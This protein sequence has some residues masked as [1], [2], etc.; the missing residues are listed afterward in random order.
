MLSSYSFLK[1]GGG[2]SRLATVGSIVGVHGG[3]SF[4]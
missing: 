3:G 1:A 4:Q 2:Y